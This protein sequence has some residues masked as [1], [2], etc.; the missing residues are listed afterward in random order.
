M[1]KNKTDSGFHSRRALQITS[2][3]NEQFR[4]LL[5][6]L[7]SKG[8]KE[9]S[10]FFLMGEK[11]VSEFLNAPEKGF[12]VDSVISTENVD[13]T[14][15]VRRTILSSD[16]FAELDILGTN[17]PMLLL[18]FKEHDE[19]LNE[20]QP[21]GLEI[22]CPL[23]DPRN[24][25]ALA[26]TSLA[27]GVSKI[28]L[29]QDSAHPYLPHAVKAS[30]GAVLKM[31]FNKFAGRMETIKIVGA[32]Y[33]LNLMGEDLAKTSLPQ[34][35]RLWVGEEGPGLKLSTEQKKIMKNLNIKTEGVESLNAALSAGIAIWEWKKQNEY[36]S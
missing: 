18:K 12:E 17:S 35:M 30:S 1:S 34:N 8:I 5:T 29:T 25:G 21:H 13:V 16:L 31:N 9:Q 19:F 15:D 4:V 32:N 28:I 36:K 10:K 11:L 22:I 33:A 23:G 20:V 2:K 3:S 14:T 27:L 24:L 26:R 6:L 7:N